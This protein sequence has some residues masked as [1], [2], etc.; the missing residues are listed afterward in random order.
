METSQLKNWVVCYSTEEII[1]VIKCK[2]A[3]DREHFTWLSQ[4]SVRKLI[5][6]SSHMFE[7]ILD[8][9]YIAL[10]LWKNKH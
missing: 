2:K 10:L 4:T 7:A 9:F 8:G 6:L 3:P 5:Y 1:R